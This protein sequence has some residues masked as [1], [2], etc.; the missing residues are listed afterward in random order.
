MVQDEESGVAASSANDDDASSS[1]NSASRRSL[2]ARSLPVARRVIPRQEP[3]EEQVRES[4]AQQN[5]LPIGMPVDIEEERRREAAAKRR[6]MRWI[7]FSIVLALLF[8]IGTVLGVTLR[9]SSVP[10]PSTTT[11][12][13]PTPSP[14]SQAFAS[15]QSLIRSVS[16]D[17]GRTLEDASSPQYRALE[18]LSENEYLET[19]P[20]WRRIQRYALAVFFFATNGQEWIVNRAW[21]SDDDEC[22]W[23]TAALDDTCDIEGK[24]LQLAMPIEHNNNVNGT[25]PIE[26]G[27][28]SDTLGE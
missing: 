3:T 24:F 1:S 19:Y 16:L 6:H 7:A 26:L 27:L 10:P 22:T 8:L 25:I 4:Q 13:S 5:D 2:S 9:P 21:N 23:A 28:L 15:V 18:W 20:D 12:V 11:A 14:T 17:D